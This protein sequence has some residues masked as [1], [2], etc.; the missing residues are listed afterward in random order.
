MVA[1]DDSHAP[2]IPSVARETTTLP[3][4]GN[5]I[6]LPL[7]TP[8]DLNIL[9]ALR[10]QNITCKYDYRTLMY[11]TSHHISSMIPL[12]SLSPQ[13]RA[14]SVSLLFV[15]VP[16]YWNEAMQD[17]KWKATVIEMCALAKNE[18]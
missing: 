15:N 4:S 6:P 13:C 1:F 2:P 17:P 12:E 16:K 14:F 5:I 18:T 10:M 7:S 9:I 11:S 8:D 3:I